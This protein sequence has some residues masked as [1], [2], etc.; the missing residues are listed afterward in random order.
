MTAHAADGERTTSARVVLRLHG[1]KLQIDMEVPDGPRRPVELMP[2]FRS[3]TDTF[4]QIAS[5]DAQAHGFSVSCA[6][7]CGACCRQLVP[8]SALDVEALEKVL[9]AM[10]ETR[11]REIMERFARALKQLESAGLIEPLRSA[12]QLDADDLQRLGLRYFAQHIPCPFLEEESCSIHEQR[13]LACREYLVTSP[14]QHCARP[15]A[16]TIRLVDMPVRMSHAVRHI[17]ATRSK[18]WTPMILAF[19]GA[20]ALSGELRS[21]PEMLAAVFEYLSGQS[22]AAP[23]T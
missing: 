23:A 14:P 4:V 9:N 15:S 2:L 20:Q 5:D 22:I 3:L 13:P 11:R 8:V 18:A 7:G 6:K 10:P 21:G 19:V 12:A 1:R 17:D 16:A